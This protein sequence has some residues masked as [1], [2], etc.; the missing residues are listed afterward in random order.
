MRGSSCDLLASSWSWSYTL[1]PNR[2]DITN[3]ETLTGHT[4]NAETLTGHTLQTLKPPVITKHSKPKP[5][6]ID[7]SR[8]YAKKWICLFPFPHYYSRHLAKIIRS[9][10][11]QHQ[12]C[13]LDINFLRFPYVFL[14]PRWQSGCRHSNDNGW[15]NLGMSSFQNLAR[16]MLVLQTQSQSSCH[17]LLRS[18]SDRWEQFQSFWDSALKNTS[19]VVW[20]FSQIHIPKF[21]PPS[22]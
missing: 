6:Q 22:W 10:K 21:N 7:I 17:L 16:F 20:M 13:L 5:V 11:S 4:A 12:K 1:Y 2:T 8:S 15:A 9:M 19:A 18:L 14:N 3:P